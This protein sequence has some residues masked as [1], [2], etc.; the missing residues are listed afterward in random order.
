MHNTDT[1]VLD[2]ETLDDLNAQPDAEGRPLVPSPLPSKLFQEEAFRYVSRWCKAS[3]EFIAKKIDRWKLLEDLYH[4]RR[5][6][7]SWGARSDLVASQNREGL[8]KGSST[9]KER[10]QA[11]IILSPSYIVDSWVDRAYQAIVSGPE[12]LTVIVEEQQ[13]SSDDDLRFPAAYKLQELLLSRLAQGQIHLRLYEILQHLVLFGS[14]Y[15]KIFWYSR[16][17]TRHRWDYETLDVRENEETIYDCPIV[18]V[19]PL[20]RLLVDWTAT[21]SDVQRHAGIGHRVDKTVQHVIE[22]FERG[23]YTLNKDAFLDRWGNAPAGDGIAV[24]QLLHDEDS[25]DLDGDEI[26]KV[27]VWEWHG[28]VPTKNGHKECLCTFITD[29]GSDSPEDA[30]DGAAHR[31]AGVVVRAQALPGCALYALGRAVRHGSGRKQS[32]SDP[33]HIPVHQSVPGQ[34]EAHRQCAA[35][36]AERFVSRPSDQHR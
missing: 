31:S 10:W 16:T 21:H 18:Q 34:C 29:K 13:E 3:C 33:L 11:D 27:T 17:V 2:R 23:V 35:H 24:D 22:Q 19:I 5:E 25:D 7:N 28:R 26:G 32:G 9:G 12:W 20:D 15:A 6:L 36:G 14:V 30:R 8:K 1:T 4:N